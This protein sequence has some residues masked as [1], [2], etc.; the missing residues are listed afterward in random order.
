MH[1]SLVPRP[2]LPNS[3]HGNKA[4][5]VYQKKKIQKLAIALYF[6]VTDYVHVTIHR[7]LFCLSDLVLTLKGGERD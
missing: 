6:Q 2:F 5:H 3:L 7:V 4:I 1:T